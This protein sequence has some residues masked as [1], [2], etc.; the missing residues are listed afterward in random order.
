M[1]KSKLFFDCKLFRVDR[2]LNGGRRNKLPAFRIN[3]TC[4]ISICIMRKVEKHSLTVLQ[5]KLADIK[6]G[7]ILFSQDEPARLRFAYNTGIIISALSRYLTRSMP[8]L[9]MVK[10]HRV[11]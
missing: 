7:L 1:N 9:I 4:W 6:T 3:C 2:L 5:Y 11:L 8:L 10:L